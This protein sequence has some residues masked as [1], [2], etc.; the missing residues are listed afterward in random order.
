MV[1]VIQPIINLLYSV[2]EEYE[3]RVFTIKKSIEDN[4]ISK[5]MIDNIGLDSRD[6]QQYLKL[7]KKIEDTNNLS[8]ITE[9]DLLDRLFKDNELDDE[10]KN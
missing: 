6:Y 9:L 7:L 5:D 8:F 3:N 4:T 10:L 1:E 2:I